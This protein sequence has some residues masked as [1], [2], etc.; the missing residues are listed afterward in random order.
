MN[1]FLKAYEAHKDAAL[2][3]V[4]I[5]KPW[6][7]SPLIRI[8][9]ADTAIRMAVRIE[10]GCTPEEAAGREYLYRWHLPLDQWRNHAEAKARSMPVTGAW[11]VPHAIGM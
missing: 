5:L 3:A 1:R 9:G 7:T 6:L 8:P 10:S 11:P 4:A 2:E